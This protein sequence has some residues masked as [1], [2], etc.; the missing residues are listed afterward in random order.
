LT[1]STPKYQATVSGDTRGL[2]LGDGPVTMIFQNGETRT[3]EIL[4][5]LSPIEENRMQAEDWKSLHES[6]QRISLKLVQVRWSIV[7]E[8]LS[9]VLLENLWTFDCRDLIQRFIDLDSLPERTVRREFVTESEKTRWLVQ[10][11]SYASELD[12]IIGQCVEAEDLRVRLEAVL[13]AL[14]RLERISNHLLSFLDSRLQRVIK[15]LDQTIVQARRVLTEFPIS[16]PSTAT[17]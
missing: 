10:L 12:G 4:K 11:G 3:V 1:V 7:G 5:L 15:E 14:L 17:S 8:D 6:F 2:V 16:T 9:L 13:A